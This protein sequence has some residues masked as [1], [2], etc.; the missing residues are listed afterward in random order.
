MASVI[1]LF[2]SLRFVQ[3]FFISFLISINY[4][5]EANEYSHWIHS[6][7]QRFELKEKFINWG[8]SYSI[9]PMKI[10]SHSHVG[11]NITTTHLP[12]R[13]VA[14]VNRDTYT[15]PYMRTGF[16]VLRQSRR[17]RSAD[18]GREKKFFTFVSVRAGDV[19]E[20]DEKLAN[21]WLPRRDVT[22]VTMVA[23]NFTLDRIGKETWFHRGERGTRR[24]RGPRAWCNTAMVRSKVR[25]DVDTGARGRR[26]RS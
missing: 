1:Q 12:I 9:I 16:F 26:R 22:G 21:R 19:A 3:L 15:V 17:L 14:R 13:R 6:R 2:L 8:R 5:G 11:S 20:M 10:L 24:H 18:S 7:V 25:V 4:G 23:R